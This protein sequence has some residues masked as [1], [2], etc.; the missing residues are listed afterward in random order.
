M[1]AHLPG[2]E[3]WHETSTKD[4]QRAIRRGERPKI[5]DDILKSTHPV[6]VVLR[7]ALDMCWVFNPTKRA[8]ANE[9]A[10]FLQ[11]RLR[12]IKTTNNQ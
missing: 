11:Q 9:V 8:K 6:D 4:A 10:A 1:Y 2:N 12:D 5:P 7:E 3:V